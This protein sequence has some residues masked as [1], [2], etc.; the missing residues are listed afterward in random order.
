ML[1]IRPA[2]SP[3][4]RI[5]N[6]Y[7]FTGSPIVTPTIDGVFTGLFVDS[8]GTLTPGAGV[9]DP[10]AFV[11]EKQFDALDNVYWHDPTG[12]FRT[13]QPLTMTLWLDGDDNGIYQTAPFTDVVIAGVIPISGTSG[14]EL[15]GLSAFPTGSSPLGFSPFVYSDAEFMYA[16]PPKWNGTRRVRTAKAELCQP[17]AEN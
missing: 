6:V 13:W 16:T 4:L 8:D 12:L 14:S 5:T 3:P 17:S 1:P 15:N 7:S 2:S 11:D 9:K 10:L